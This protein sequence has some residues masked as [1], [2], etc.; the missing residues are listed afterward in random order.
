MLQVGP[1]RGPAAFADV[2][3]V[4]PDVELVIETG[5]SPSSLS[6]PSGRPLLT[7]VGVGIGVAGL[8]LLS[9]TVGSRAAA[10]RAYDEERFEAGDAWVRVNQ[11]TAVAGFVATGLGV[12]LVVVG[13]W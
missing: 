13:R 10:R 6:R 7:G 3:V 5:V 2:V 11:T 12:G 9:T 1:R 8:A 4:A